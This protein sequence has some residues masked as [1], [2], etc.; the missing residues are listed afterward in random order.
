MLDLAAMQVEA[1]H[2]VAFYGMNHPENE[3]QRFA[4]H[5]PSHV[6][7]EPTPPAAK[8]R[9]RLLGRMLWSTSAARGMGNVLDDFRPDVV[10][11]HN[12]YHQLSPSVLRPIAARGI[13]AVL[14]LHDYKLACPTYRMLD[15]GKICDA[16][17]GGHFQQAALRRC[18][19]DSLLASAAAGAELWIHTV[20]RAYAPVKVFI[21]PS[22]FMHSIMKRAGVFPERLQWIP[23]FVEPSPGHRRPQSSVVFAGRLSPEKGVD[24][25]IRAMGR[26]GRD[27][28]LD[29]AGTG[30]EHGRLERLADEFA[31]GQV[32]FHGRLDRAATLALVGDASAVA[33]PSR[34]YENQPMTV[35][36]AFAAGR[37]VVASALGGIPE[38]IDDGVDGRLVPYDDVEA[39]ADALGPLL[40]DADKADAMGRAGLAKV[41]RDYAPAR[42]LARLMAAYED[43]SG[44]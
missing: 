12:I 27:C 11:L 13:G 26:L 14:T 35:L 17:V 6:E 15:R 39:M 41:Q 7:F 18:K 40:R 38:L 24:T 3:P 21:C 37:P 2:Q 30:P 29:I 28:R 32:T 23:H 36:E 9:V 20:L 31:P 8:D 25:L 22:Q 10:H 34:W 16:C 43:T 44:R 42:H 1:G 5:F 4:R 33:V 19:D